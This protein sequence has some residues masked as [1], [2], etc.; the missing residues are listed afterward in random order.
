MASNA[1]SMIVVAAPECLPDLLIQEAIPG[2]ACGQS[3]A[4]LAGDFER[5][6]HSSLRNIVRTADKQLGSTIGAQRT[7]QAGAHK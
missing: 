2:H 1:E 7:P 3:R 6:G 5:C 4:T